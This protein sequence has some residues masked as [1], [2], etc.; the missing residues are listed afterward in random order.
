MDFD[1]YLNSIRK[2]M[3]RGQFACYVGITPAH[4]S[5]V[6]HGRTR[7][8]MCLAR[9]IS[10]I[11]GGIVKWQDLMERKYKNDKKYDNDEK[12]KMIEVKDER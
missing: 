5:S 10:D 1:D 11:S 7:P 12:F 8:S 9:R 3:T 6:I 4:L 2:K